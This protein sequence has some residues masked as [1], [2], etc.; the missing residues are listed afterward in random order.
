V[1]AVDVD[2][3]EHRVADAHSGS[4]NSIVMKVR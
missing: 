1:C 2:L 4:P 3:R